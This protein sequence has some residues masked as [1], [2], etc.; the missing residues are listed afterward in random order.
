MRKST[1]RRFATQEKTKQVDFFVSSS[2]ASR[3]GLIAPE[4]L[5]WRLFA[6]W[7]L[8][9]PPTANATRWNLVECICKTLLNFRARLS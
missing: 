2:I 9:Q 3:V 6:T 1:F 4:I 8:V 7:G 5:K